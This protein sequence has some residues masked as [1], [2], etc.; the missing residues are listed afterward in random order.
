MKVKNILFFLTINYSLLTINCFAQVQ[1]EW[2]ARYNSQYNMDDGPKKMTLDKF[3]NI[4]VT[5]NII[6]SSQGSDFATV[7]YNPSGVQQW[8][9]TYNQISNTNEQATGIAA[10]S[11]GNIFITGSTGYNLGPFDIVTIKYNSSGVQQWAKLYNGTAGNTDDYAGDIATDRAGNIYLCGSTGFWYNPGNGVLIKYNTNG[12]SIWVRRYS[13]GGLTAQYYS[14]AIDRFNNVYATG[15]FTTSNRYHSLTVKYDSSGVLQWAAQYVS[16]VNNNDNSLKLALDTSRNAYVT[17]ATYIGSQSSYLTIKYSSSGTQQW[18][19]NYIGPIG[20]G[21]H[22]ARSIV[23]DKFGY[24]YVTGQSQSGG[25]TYDVATIKYN[26]NGD[27]LWVRR[28]ITSGGI[29]VSGRIAIAADDSANIY[30]IATPQTSG[31]TTVKYSTGGVQQ[32]VVSYPGSDVDITI[33]NLRNVYVTGYNNLGGTGADYVTIKYSQ[34]VGIE[35]ISGELPGEFKLEQNYPNPFNQSTIINYQLPIASNVILRVYD[36]LGREMANLVNEELVPGTYQVN[37]D[38]ANYPSGV[39]Y[40]KMQAGD[41]SE[42]KKM[43]LIK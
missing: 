7:K 26:S 11:S 30:V 33:D 22:E 37:F 42:T 14:M 17:G 19:R 16:N 6:T 24:A 21:G 38:A 41:F 28:F 4:C 34:P 29:F 3:G 25:S 15:K 12:D 32:W 20:V 5:G 36:I 1:Q 39:Y 18:V 31:I 40:Y 8:V 13:V 2:V 10:D 23:T 9:A 27:S 35:P 43:I